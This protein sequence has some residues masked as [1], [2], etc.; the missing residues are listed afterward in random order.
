MDLVEFPPLDLDDGEKE[1]GRLVTTADDP[2]TALV[3]LR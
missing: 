1:F 3:G 2:L